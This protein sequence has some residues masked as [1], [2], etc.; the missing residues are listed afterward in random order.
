MKPTLSWGNLPDNFKVNQIQY[1][2]NIFDQNSNSLLAYGNGRSYGDV[3]VNSTLITLNNLKKFIDIDRVNNLITCTSN[4]TVKEVLDFLIPKGYFL[5]VVP[6]TQNI[7][8]GGAVANDIHGKNHHTSGSIGNFIKK[9]ELHR[10]DKGIIFCDEINDNSLFF[11]T[12]GGLGLTG[13]IRSV[14]IQVKKI[15]SE[16][17][18]SVCEKFYS[19]EEF[20][21]INR[22]LEKKYEYCVG[23][24]DLVNIKKSGFRGLLLAGN[25]SKSNLQNK[26]TFPTKQF[27][28]NFPFTPSFSLVNKLTIKILNFLYFYFVGRNKNSIQL[29][30]KFFFPLDVINF[31]NKAYGKKGFFQY[32]F[33]VPYK[34]VESFFNKFVECLKK[35]N[36]LPSLTVLKSFGDIESVG[37]M[38]FP[39]KGVTLAIDFPNKG[40]STQKL[41]DELDL[42]VNS[43]EGAIYP[44]KDSRM[45]KETFHKSFPQKLHFEKNIDPLFSSNFWERVR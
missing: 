28:I 26:N 4:M 37:M 10:S 23:W 14:T 33:V 2:E 5:P 35:Y 42:L 20:L 34:N 9:I 29:Y 15:E 30:K 1:S 21:N 32:Q 27:S 3:C 38:S 7:T 6:G 31:W 22:E 45:S 39:R 19:F 13:I 12:I 16:F 43:Y 8:I 25:H 18:D 17:I 36:E 40:N 24:V 41:F 44:A 11:S